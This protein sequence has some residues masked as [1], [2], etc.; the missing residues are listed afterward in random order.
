AS[1]VPQPQIDAV[2]PSLLVLPPGTDLHEHAMVK[3]GRLVLQGACT[4]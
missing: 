4:P 3:D 2:V 1:L